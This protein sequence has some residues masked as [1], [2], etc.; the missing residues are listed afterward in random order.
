LARVADALGLPFEVVDSAVLNALP[1]AV[2]V[3]DRDGRIVGFNRRAVELW[4]REP[5]ADDRFCGSL[6]M[7]RPDGSVLAH[8]EC[9]M[10]D[11]LQTGE[12]VRDA[13]V[14]VERPDGSRVSVN[15][16]IVP[17][18]NA[19]G[20]VAGA[21]NTFQDVQ[22]LE[23]AADAASRRERELHDFVENA[24]EGLHWAGPDGLIL[25]ANR[26]E[27][28]LLGYSREE[29]IGHH[30]AEFHADRD[31]IDDILARLWRNESVHEHEARMRCRDGSIRHVLI[32]SS[33]L[34]RDGQFVHTRCFTRDV[35]DRKRAEE[36]RSQIAEQLAVELAATQRLHETS[37]QLIRENDVAGLY[38]RILDAA[39]A[40]MHSE[41]ASMQIVDAGRDALVM[42]AS[43]GFDPAFDTMFALN[44]SDARTSCSVARRVRHRVV[45]P[46]VETCDFIAGTPALDDH[47]KAGIRAVQST[48]LVSRSGQLLG[49]ISTHWR[50]PHQPSEDNLRLLDV[51]SRQAADLIE[52]TQAETAAR[53]AEVQLRRAS[54]LLEDA[55]HARDDFLSTAAHELRNPVNALQLQLVALLRAT[56]ENG[57]AVP[58]AW[59]RDRIGQAVTA[60]RRLVKLVETL[61]DVS[62]ITA[63][64]LD[65]EPEPMDFGQAVDAV[66]NRFKDQLKERQ[67]ITRVTQT[68][69]SWDRLRVEQIVT[70][71]LSNAMKFGEGLPIEISLEEDEATICLRVT[72]HGIGIEPDDQKRLFERF[73][74][75]VSRRQYGGFGL[76]LWITQQIVDAMGGRIAVDSHPGE[77]STFRVTLPR[78]PVGTTK[79][80]REGVPL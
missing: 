44:P 34:W 66:V 69:G 56:Q 45:V 28:D 74:R 38:Q 4:G 73:E 71:L 10:A 9:P 19:A 49:I 52:R 31:V 57:E 47:R 67:I 54:Q 70:N 20:Q 64:R 36:A 40:I 63:G 27:L 5:N 51:L 13:G 62:S 48:P 58:Q 35:T 1:V 41:M 61:L 11:V 17:L 16:T 29:Y 3:C 39:V 53:A 12:A 6:R 7:I 15:V 50:K 26:A 37:S 60:V 32:N 22:E 8:H 24:T 59:A 76:G 55:V 78:Q 77:G 65:L 75:A 2:Y 80:H 33:V 25:W 30:I 68:P 72:D 18:T 14:I 21:V 23:R 43:R 46:D 79:D 42:L